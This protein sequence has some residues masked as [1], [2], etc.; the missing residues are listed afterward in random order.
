[1]NHAQEREAL[2]WGL[3]GVTLFAA[4]LPMT[5]LAVGPVDAPQLSPWFVTFGRAAVAG[6]LSVAYLAWQRGRGQ[7]NVPRRAE[8]PLLGVTAF[9]V[10]V[11]FPLFLAL[12]L[13]HVP[14]THGAVVTALLPLSTAVLGALWYRQRPSAGFWVCA[15][16]GSGLV[17]GFMAWRAGGFYLGAANIYLI[18]AMTTG[19]F[20][21]IGGARLTPSLGAEQAI[22]WVL[23]LSLPLTLPV[24]CWFAPA[25]PG[26]VST[27]AWTGFAYVAL[28]SMW[29]GFFAWYRALALGAVR[30]SQIQLVQPFLSLL[31]A[32]PLLGERLD[33][34]T[35]CFALAVIATVFV[36]K[37]MPVHQGAA[38]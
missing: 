26:A 13:R 30:V 7:L 9:G 20:G 25:V 1:M 24:A 14:S 35:A 2:V 31:F 37:K 18:I 21:Y 28:F 12:A 8:W 3:V 33:L 15:V 34:M 36:G 27:M 32:V 11:G 6:L 38:A 10:I 17:L 29:I 4:T 23:A 5:R 22:C 16:V 19:A